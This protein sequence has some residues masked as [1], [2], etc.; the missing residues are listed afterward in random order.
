M[1]SI[2]LPYKPE[3]NTIH[4]HVLINV[5]KYVN[6]NPGL[7]HCVLS[8][9]F[10]T[11]LWKLFYS[12]RENEHKWQAVLVCKNTLS[13]TIFCIWYTCTRMN[14]SDSYGTISIRYVIDH[15]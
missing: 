3:V 10:Y 13:T 2:V 11:N 8:P 4:I 15:I 1:K 6:S 5:R 7:I 14:L 12:E 9:K